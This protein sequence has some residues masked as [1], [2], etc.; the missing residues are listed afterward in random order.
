MIDSLFQLKK[1]GTFFLILV[2]LNVFSQSPKD[3]LYIIWKNSSIP[4][5][6]RA[7]A[8]NKLI[9]E[10]YVDSKTDSGYIM[11]KELQKFTEKNNL[12]RE[13]A[14]VLITLGNIQYII[15][16][17][18]KA[19]EN[20]RESLEI[21]KLLNDKLGEA[22]ALN[23]IGR[24]YKVNWNFDKAIEYYQESLE[25]S[26]DLNDTISIATNLM[27]IGNIYNLRFKVDKALEYYQESL[28]LSEAI[29]DKTGI[30]ITYL[31][32]GQNYT[33]RKDYEKAAYY[34]RKG[35]NIS[36]E[37]NNYNIETNALFFVAQNYFSQKK[38][39]EAIKYCNLSIIPAEKIS[40]KAMLYANQE[41]IAQSYRGKKQWKLALE[42]LEKSSEIHDY[43]NELESSKELQKMEINNIHI[44]DSLYLIQKELKLDLAHQTELQQK[45]KE[46]SNLILG[47]GISLFIISILALL[48]FSNIKQKQLKAEKE[49]EKILKE[50][51]LSS[52]DAMIEGQE[53]E[54]K[55]IAEDLHDDIGSVLTTLKLHFENFKINKEKQQFLQEELI[56]KTE[57]LLD[58]AYTKVRSMAHARN[59]GVI[60]NQG[61]LIA[62]HNMAT[63]ISNA[64]KIAINVIDHGLENRLENSLEL[65]I[66]RIIQE[67][68]TNTIKHANA[69]EI[70]V[71]LTNHEEML[72]IM[73]EDDGVG[74]DTKTVSKN[75]GMGLHSIE[76]RIEHL[77]GTLIIESEKNKGTTVIID[78][79]TEPIQSIK[80]SK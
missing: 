6:T 61:L 73:V 5:S 66:F 55:R 47:W 36:K 10:K 24:M 22:N 64:D 71:H 44:K 76:K 17:L 12:N 29:N 69:N 45:N 42:H 63:K 9:L 34:I 33:L 7:I 27:N 59:S 38:Y 21:Y 75:K 14:D 60:A 13:Y 18:T 1:T 51:E 23:N 37:I 58:E 65:T 40:N 4:D 11:A 80:N 31:N 19:T 74:F 79:P 72:N 49:K 57:T 30:A 43:L 48:I 50:I 25:I 67:L 16:D 70:N 35:L 32:L 3:S 8:Y 54:R 78:I 77:E 41:L 52:I 68:V 39:N 2:A 62:V 28:K 56:S 26:K 15:G 53:K 20:Y 46:K